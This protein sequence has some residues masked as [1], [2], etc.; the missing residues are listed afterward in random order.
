MGFNGW[1]YGVAVSLAVLA[2]ALVLT[3][4]PL[5]SSGLTGAIGLM[6]L[7]GWPGLLA[8]AFLDMR[9]SDWKPIVT[10][11]IVGL[12]LPFVNLLVG[13]AY[14]YRRHTSTGG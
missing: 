6:I 8:T 9:H 12:L 1:Y 14:L 11:W 7:V 3:L 13:A 5:R 2:V 4:T 10:L